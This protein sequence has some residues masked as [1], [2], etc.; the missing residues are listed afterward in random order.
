MSS[1]ENKS[2]S[3]KLDNNNLSSPLQESP[4]KIFKEENP[5]KENIIKRNLLSSKSSKQKTECFTTP[6]DSSFTTKQNN[7]INPL[8][9][10]PQP[11]FNSSEISKC[12][13]FQSKKINMLDKKENV[14]KPCCCCTK[15]KCI[16][17]YCECFA[18]NRY[19]KDCHCI[20][21][22]NKF[23]YLNNNNN[24]RE[25]FENEI[26]FCTC[27]KSN[28]NKKYCECYKSGKKC[29]D[30]CRCVNCLNNISPTFNI[31]NNSISNNDNINLN[32]DN[33]LK[34]LINKP[35]INLDEEKSNSR[36]SSSCEDSCGNYK[37]QRISVFI[38]QY[39]TLV[40][41]EKF[42]NEDMRLIAK[43]RFY[44]K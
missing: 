1:G 19:C 44:D 4:K 7:E 15:T 11:E 10:F 20:D 43:K 29:N 23:I 30:K 33:N 14:E 28:C 2:K 26:I 18:N 9:H 6:S 25:S 16:K 13:Y 37:I 41:V 36:K 38:N 5:E 21:C 39:Q 27:A 17:K 8:S 34:E 3:E 40:N 12:T 35:K 42:S 22:M 24:L 31:I 32:E